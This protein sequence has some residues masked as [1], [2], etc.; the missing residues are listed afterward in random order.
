M[1]SPARTAASLLWNARREGGALAELPAR[2]RPATRLAGQRHIGVSG[3]LAG[4]V[5]ATFAHRDGATLSL[6][7]N[8]M[9]VA[10]A[11]FGFFLAR[12]LAPRAAPYA[13]AE[14]LAA[15]GAVVPVIEVPDSRFLDF[16]R[17]G[18]A[19]LLA[20]DACA[21]QFVLGAGA[22]V[23]WRTLDLRAHPATGRVLRG[24][25]VAVEHAGTGEAVLGDPRAAL[26]WLVNE[27]S[28]LGIVLRAGEFVST[29]TCFQPLPIAPGDEI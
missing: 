23:D 2:C 3:P 1:E 12:D 9:R 19:Q 29:G 4:R 13:V 27:L 14:V 15:V 7:G 6:A 16:V 8:R 11:E 21:G 26:T 17:A 10:E 22:G 18:E 25:A 28:G 20:D 5:L 24:G